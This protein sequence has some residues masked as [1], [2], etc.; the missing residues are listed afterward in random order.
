MPQP[1]C[2]GCNLTMVAPRDGHEIA[3]GWAVVRIEAHGNATLSIGYMYVCPN[4]L[5][6]VTPKQ[7]SLLNEPMKE[8]P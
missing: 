8:Q 6:S 7:T 5:F 3:P 1:V 2:A 4:C